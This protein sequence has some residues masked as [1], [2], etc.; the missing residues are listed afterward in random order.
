[1]LGGAAAAI[2]TFA[3]PDALSAH[4][5]DFFHSHL[6][7]QLIFAWGYVRGSGPAGASLLELRARA[8]GAT[9]LDA[10]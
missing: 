4:C 6:F 1:M 2:E 10:L 3:L 9:D 7:T 5:C 8:V